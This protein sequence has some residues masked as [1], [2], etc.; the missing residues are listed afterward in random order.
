MHMLC[1]DDPAGTVAPIVRLDR[2][3]PLTM[4]F[5]QGDS[6]G[7]TCILI[8]GAKSFYSIATWQ[9]DDSII[10]YRPYSML[11]IMCVAAT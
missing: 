7:H 4:T 2:Q 10:G 9:P 11:Y 3:K 8:I 5:N 1:S 6:L